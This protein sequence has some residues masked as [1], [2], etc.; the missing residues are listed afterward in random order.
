MAHAQTQFKQFHSK[1]LLGYDDNAQLR[2]RRDTLLSNLKDNI[3]KDAPAYTH[4][5]QG[6]YALSTGVTPVD[7]DPDMD[8]GLIFDCAPSDYPDPLVLKKYVYES[9]W[10]Q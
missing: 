8:I 5:Q 7:R 4:F 3:S 6:S 1:I 2:E 10:N 9:P